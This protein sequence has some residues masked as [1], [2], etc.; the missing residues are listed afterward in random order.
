LEACAK[1]YENQMKKRKIKFNLMGGGQVTFDRSEIRGYVKD[2]YTSITTVHARGEL[3]I[4]RESI[5]EISQML[6]QS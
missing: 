1:A 4:V 3:W 5:E 6:N 2:V